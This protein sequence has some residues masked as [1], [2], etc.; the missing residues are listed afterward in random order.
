VGLGQ[1][2][3]VRDATA[4]DDGVDELAVLVDQVPGDGR[5]TV[6][7]ADRSRLDESRCCE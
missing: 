5:R 7:R 4:E 3:E 6:I 2:R 1:R